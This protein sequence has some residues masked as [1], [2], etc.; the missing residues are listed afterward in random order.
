M[1]DHGVS[2]LCLMKLNLQLLELQNL[3]GFGI[4]PVPTTW[5]VPSRFIA[6]SKEQLA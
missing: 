2:A 3:F 5:N 4:R 1:S 6:R